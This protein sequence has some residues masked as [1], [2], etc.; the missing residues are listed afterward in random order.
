[1]GSTKSKNAFIWLVLM[2]VLMVGAVVVYTLFDPTRYAWM[3]QCPFRVLTG[4]SCPACGLQRAFHALLHGRF[5]EALAYN[6]FFVFSIPYALALIISSGL[7]YFGKGEK[8]VRVVEHPLFARTYIVL[9]FVWGVV[10]NIM[11]I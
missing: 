11:N 6:Y 7:K 9:F 2:L 8:Y 1:V 5:A 4:W 3:P 10:R